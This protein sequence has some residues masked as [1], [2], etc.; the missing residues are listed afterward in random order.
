[1]PV[2]AP[3][4]R[5]LP[6]LPIALLANCGTKTPTSLPSYSAQIESAV[7]NRHVAD[8]DQL[9]PVP[10]PEI[11]QALIDTLPAKLEGETD[12]GYRD[13][14]NPSQLGI[15]EWFNKEIGEGKN[16]QIYCHA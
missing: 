14:L 11:A 8:C 7:R 16:W 13:R 15:F 4:M 12:I 9:K 3:M 5:L 6:F 2:I 1:M 10:I